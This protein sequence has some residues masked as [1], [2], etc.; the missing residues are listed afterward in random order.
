MAAIEISLSPGLCLGIIPVGIL[1]C[2]AGSSHA[3]CSTKHKCATPA[4]FHE[5]A[6]GRNTIHRF[7]S[8]HPTH[9]VTGW[10]RSRA[11]PRWQS[12]TDTVVKFCV[13]LWA[14]LVVLPHCI[15]PR[16]AC[17]L[18]TL[19]WFV[20]C[21]GYGF[22]ATWH[23]RVCIQLSSE[24]RLP[25]LYQKDKQPSNG[26]ARLQPTFLCVWHVHCTHC[27]PFAI[28][29]TELQSFNNS[30]SFTFRCISKVSLRTIQVS[31]LD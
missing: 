20:S 19:L 5:S 13:S 25:G 26:N 16:N 23:C 21:G 10:L 14:Q 24:S 15:P 17:Y 12:I 11:G 27:N 6:A 28:F 8:S 30:R 3:N 9:H 29:N 22:V 4:H 2:L 1:P 31:N 18:P 7:L